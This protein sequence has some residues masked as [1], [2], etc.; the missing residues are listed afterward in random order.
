MSEAKNN[1]L[2]KLSALLDDNDLSVAAGILSG[3]PFHVVC[4]NESPVN[5]LLRLAK[6]GE[7]NDLSDEAYG[8][9]RNEVKK[10]EDERTA[11]YDGYV[12]CTYRVVLCDDDFDKN[13]SLTDDELRER[14]KSLAGR[15]C[16]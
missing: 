16:D 11:H 14:I 6:N 1:L 3:K 7:V 15:S 13:H 4:R 12:V 2:K 10:L 9:L 8:S 5:A